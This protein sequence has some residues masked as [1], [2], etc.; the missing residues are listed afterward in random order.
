MVIYKH[1]AKH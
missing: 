1:K